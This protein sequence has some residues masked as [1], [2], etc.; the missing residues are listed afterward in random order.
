[1]VLLE[2]QAM[3]CSDGSSTRINLNLDANDA[4]NNT[5]DYELTTSNNGG[6]FNFGV[7]DRDNT[8]ANNQGTVNFNP[9]ITDFEDI[10]GPVQLPVLP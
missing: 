7:Q 9:L 6:G 10:P 3:S 2:P 1:M 4:N 5:G 8:D